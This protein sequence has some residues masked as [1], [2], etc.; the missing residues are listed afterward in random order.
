MRCLGSRSLQSLG[1]GW[2]RRIPVS[3][4]GRL[5]LVWENS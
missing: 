5:E 4:L 1:K 3:F 2:G